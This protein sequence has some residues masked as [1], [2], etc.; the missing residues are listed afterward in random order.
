MESLKAPATQYT[1]AMDERLLTVAA[2][3]RQQGRC[4]LDCRVAA[5]DAMLQMAARAPAGVTTCAHPA[6]W[7]TLP[8][9]VDHRPTCQQ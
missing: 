5:G 9:R 7:T 1:S 2:S 8:S 6:G 3:C 4:L